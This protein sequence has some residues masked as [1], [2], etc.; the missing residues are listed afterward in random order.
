MDFPRIFHALSI[1]YPHPKNEIPIYGDNPGISIET[2]LTYI[3]R[4]ILLKNINCKQNS[5]TTVF[6]EW[7]TV[8]K[9]KRLGHLRADHYKAVYTSVVDPGFPV[10]WVWTS[11]VSA[12]Q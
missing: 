3:A 4:G 10:G 7:K 1:F 6:A 9:V 5:G 2:L 12:F 8:T 11:D